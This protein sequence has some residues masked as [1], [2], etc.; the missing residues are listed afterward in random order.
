MGLKNETL[1]LVCDPVVAACSVQSRARSKP[2]TVTAIV[3][4][5]GPSGTEYA[6]KTP[7]RAASTR[8]GNSPARRSMDRLHL[9]QN[10]YP[11]A[12]ASHDVCARPCGAASGWRS[13]TSSR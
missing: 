13:I 12:R 3:D 6:P 2:L 10:L 9:L 4:G 8:S 11:Q 7:G 1:V 5:R